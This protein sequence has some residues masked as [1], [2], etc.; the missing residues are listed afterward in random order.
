MFWSH[1]A[2]F[3]YV[4]VIIMSLAYMQASWL[5]L[6]EIICMVWFGQKR[7]HLFSS[8]HQPF[9]VSFI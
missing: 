1:K 5:K 6:T 2:G 3:T 8:S 4:C 7:K 9:E